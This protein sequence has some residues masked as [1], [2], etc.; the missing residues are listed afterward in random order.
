[1]CDVASHEAKLLHFVA[2]RFVAEAG[3]A[4]EP[5]IEMGGI[6]KLFRGV[7]LGGAAGAAGL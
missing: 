2:A 1:M 3:S 4:V 5:R 7:E 6:E